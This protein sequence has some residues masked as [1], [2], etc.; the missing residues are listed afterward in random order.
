M[1]YVSDLDEKITLIRDRFRPI[2]GQEIHFYEVAHLWDEN[3][4]EWTEWM[5]VPLFLTIGPQTFSISWT[6]F[7][8]LAIENERNLPFSL[9]RSTVRWECEGIAVLDGVVGKRVMSV[10][11]G[12]G[13]MTVEKQKIEIWTRLLFAL[14]DGSVLDVYNALDENGFGHLPGGIPDDA[15]TCT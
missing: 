4:S 13:S 11:I 5:D 7:D 14:D 10:A 15:K 8:E 6:R 1:K 12:K 9:C 3:G 2:V